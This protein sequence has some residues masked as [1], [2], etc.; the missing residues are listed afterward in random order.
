MEQKI[1][2][3]FLSILKFKEEYQLK[4][5]GLN[6]TELHVLESVYNT[7]GIKTLDIS[8]SLGLPPSTLISVL[9]KLE[10]MKLIKRER[11]KEDKRIVLVSLTQKGAKK[12]SSH[13][14][15]DKVFLQNI[16]SVLDEEEKQLFTKLIEKITSLTKE[17]EELFKE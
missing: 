15:E 16:I 17:P 7:K 12:V 10:A 11:Q 9:D 6:Y 5:S 8:K 2:H 4:S 14:R 3:S 1:F 13:F